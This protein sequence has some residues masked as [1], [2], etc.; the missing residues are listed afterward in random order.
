MDVLTIRALLFG[1]VLRSLAV[2]KLAQDQE[3]VQSFRKCAGKPAA[4][5][6]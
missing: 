6:F 4:L 2:E 3:T 5:A 1:S